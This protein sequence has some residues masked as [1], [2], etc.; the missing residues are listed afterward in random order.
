M[1]NIK[2]YYLMNIILNIYFLKVAIGLILIVV[3]M[4][5]D[6]GE[7]TMPTLQTHKFFQKPN[8]L[9]IFFGYYSI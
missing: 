3:N 6:I 5:I 8:H 1:R 4:S 2:T 9:P 7:W